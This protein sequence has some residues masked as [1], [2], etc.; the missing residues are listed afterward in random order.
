MSHLCGRL[1]VT[2]QGD[3]GGLSSVLYFN[4]LS[5]EIWTLIIGFHCH[6]RRA[7]VAGIVVSCVIIIIRLS[8]TRQCDTGGLWNV[9]Q[10]AII[11]NL[12]TYHRFSLSHPRSWGRRYCGVVCRNHY[13]TF[14]N[15][16]GRISSC[17]S[18]RHTTVFRN[19][20]LKSCQPRNHPSQD[21]QTLSEGQ[22]TP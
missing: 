9:F 15:D 14:A 11:W 8:Q 20:I 13:P 6:I 19:C 10:Y 21:E 2:S 5:F 17:P 7:G 16:V 1:C 22:H 3:T 4:M 12:N 18:K